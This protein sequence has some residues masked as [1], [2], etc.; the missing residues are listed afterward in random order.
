MVRSHI[1]RAHWHGYWTGPK[2]EPEKRKFKLLWL[3]PILVGGI[4][5][6]PGVVHMVQ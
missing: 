4:V 6:G 1:R 3:H 5:D 2:K